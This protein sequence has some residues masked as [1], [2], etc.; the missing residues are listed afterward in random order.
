[1]PK[2][3]REQTIEDVSD[4]G[5][6]EKLSKKLTNGE[7]I[8]KSKHKNP[9]PSAS[10]LRAINEAATLFKNNLFKTQLCSL[11][12]SVSLKGKHIPNVEKIIHSLY[13]FL[14]SLPA[15]S[16][17]HPLDAVH[18]L[19]VFGSGKKKFATP[20]A[21]PYPVPQPTRSMAW[22]VAF[23]APIKLNV[24]GSWPTKVMF[25]RPEKN[26]FIVDLTIEMPSSLFQEKDYRNSRFFYKRAFYLAC[27]AAALYHSDFSF[28][29]QY[30]FPEENPRLTN[31][32]LFLKSVSG[33]DDLSRLNVAIRIMPV[34]ADDIPIPR[35]RLAPSQANIRV[36]DE[37]LEDKVVDNF[38]TPIYNSTLGRVS[39]LSSR[40]ILLESHYVVE[41]VPSA[42]E[43]LALIRVWANQ[44]GYGSGSYTSPTSASESDI[45]RSQYCVRGFENLGSW[46]MCLLNVL[47]FGEEPSVHS[48]RKKS[49][50][51]M[52]MGL[53]SYQLFRGTLGFLAKHD[54]E[55]DPIFMRV[56]GTGLII[57][58]LE[59][60]NTGGP[61]FVDPT[62]LV[63]MLANVPISSLQLLAR[64]AAATLHAL[65]KNDDP[66]T[67]FM[68]DIREPQT[69]FDCTI[70]I[71]LAQIRHK[72]PRLSVDFPTVR[73]FLIN[74]LLSTVKRALGSRAKAIVALHSRSNPRPITS[75]TLLEIEWITLGIIYDPVNALSLIDHGPPVEAPESEQ[76]AFRAFWGPKADLR[77]FKDGRIVYSCVWDDNIVRVED[78]ESIPAQIVLYILNLKFDLVAPDDAVVINGDYLNVITPPPRGSVKGRGE[79]VFTDAIKAYEKFSKGLKALEEDGGLT[80]SLVV[81]KPCSSL[82]RYMSVLPPSPI[83]SPSTLS[84]SEDSL[85]LHPST[86]YLPAF[87]VI[88][89]LERSSQ[90]PD[91]IHAI[92]R[93]KMALLEEMARGFLKKNR[94]CRARVVIPRELDRG[95]SRSIVEHNAALEVIIDGWAFHAYIW[96]NREATLL[97][98]ISKVATRPGFTPAPAYERSRAQ[99]LLQNYDRL[100][101]QSPAH[102]SALL[103][104]HHKYPSL[105]TTI[106]LVKR[107][108][109][110][111]WVSTRIREEAIELLCASVYISNAYD[112]PATS[113]N[114]FM[115]VVDFL[116]TWDGILYVKLFEEA[117][118]SETQAQVEINNGDAKS[119]QI[120]AGQGS[121]R[122]ATLEDPSGTV[123]CESI[124][125]LV[126]MRIQMLAKELIKALSSYTPFT[127]KSLFVHPTG[128]YDF[129]LHLNTDVVTRYWEGI[130]SSPSTWTTGY[131]N[132]DLQ[133][134]RIDTIRVEFNP[135]EAL[136]RDMQ[137]VYADV[138]EFFYDVYGGTSVGGVWK[139]DLLASKQ[140]KVHLGYSS[141]PVPDNKNVQNNKS[142]NK[143]L[144]TLN[145]DAIMSEIRRMG[146]G[147]I[148]SISYRNS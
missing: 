1:M 8:G 47:V 50:P 57:D 15:I 110:S 73:H 51:S 49:R 54:W 122:I 81:S 26:R 103:A 145:K 34:A 102:H 115:R 121:W 114:G 76:N 108:L 118:D 16:P 91:D 41:N 83:V 28:D 61:V 22:K 71:N 106:R 98:D 107:W 140:W 131:T 136:C 84:D 104:L 6:E 18:S 25:K 128:D 130:H 144:V 139:P 42:R 4:E 63:N 40:S 123:W 39:S 117:R 31:V 35:T 68:T 33:K 138:I 62:G 124:T 97:K 46:W 7:D 44:R 127:F 45:H 135:A 86:S 143:D 99:K 38:S 66:Y 120:Q 48:S 9:L 90:W 19:S 21:I 96:H 119:M 77:R 125:P 105:S 112:V 20:V 94:N 29:V 137:D 88:V 3:K 129:L 92:H 55:K 82:L 32:L 126:S 109:G 53:S 2:R 5:L 12:Q 52:G 59:W 11:V 147:I 43:G 85:I 64:D 69:R 116:S 78:R 95:E 80:L 14:T 24:V 27:I 36:T 132:F 13:P 74:Q 56:V 146:E 113:R 134:N 101:L 58:A 79:C 72:L 75:P 89:Q 142:K 133:F 111:H 17:I 93:V 60:M 70:R 141:L 100:F 23:K 30:E 67:V 10:E 65:D 87:K 148:K 37:N